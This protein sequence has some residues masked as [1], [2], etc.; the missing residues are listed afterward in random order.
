[1]IATTTRP[2]IDPM[3]NLQVGEVA[4]KSRPRHGEEGD[5]ADFRGHDAQ[6]HCGPGHLPPADN[7]ILAI[8]LRLAHAP[9]DPADGSEIQAQ[10]EEVDDKANGRRQASGAGRAALRGSP[11][12]RLPRSRRFFPVEESLVVQGAAE[13]LPFV[14]KALH[15]AEDFFAVLLAN[16]TPEARMAQPQCVWYRGDPWPA[17]SHPTR[18]PYRP[19]ARLR[20]LGEQRGGQVAHHAPRSH[21]AP[22]VKFS[23]HARSPNPPL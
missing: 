10:N 1:M 18:G 16:R 8:P 20:R 13:A 3:P 23:L 11:R 21:R 22:P 6:E 14:F 19:I 17:Q 12:K 15:G 5:G 2:A 9:S 4:L 7:E